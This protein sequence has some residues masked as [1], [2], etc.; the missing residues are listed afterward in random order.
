MSDL[1]LVGTGRSADVFEHGADEVLRGYRAPRTEREV[2]AGRRARAS[3]GNTSERE[4][5]PSWPAGR[6]RVTEDLPCFMRKWEFARRLWIRSIQLLAGCVL[7]SAVLANPF[8]PHRLQ[9]PAQLRAI[10]R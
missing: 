8:I 6:F 5:A 4:N 2:A 7:I 10:L 9:L 1:R 3:P